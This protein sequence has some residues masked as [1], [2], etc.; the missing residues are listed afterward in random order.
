MIVTPIF[1]ERPNLRGLSVGGLTKP[2][3]PRLINFAE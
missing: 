3:V 1:G 2:I